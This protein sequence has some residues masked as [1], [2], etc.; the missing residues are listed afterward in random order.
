HIAEA[1]VRWM[2]PICSFT[3]QE[4]WQ[5]L[6]S[7]TADGEARSEYVFTQS[8]YAGFADFAQVDVDH[9]FWAELIEVRDEVNKALETARRD[10]LIGGSLHAEVTLF[11]VP[12]LAAKLERLEDELRFV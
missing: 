12:E 6:P 10:D 11:A 8:W 3:A 7:E 9:A 2:A 5:A 4:V 1:L